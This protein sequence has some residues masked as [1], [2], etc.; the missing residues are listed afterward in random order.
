M[1][2]GR[3]EAAQ[4]A[5]EAAA[6]AE[7]PDGARLEELAAR[8]TRARELYAQLDSAVMDAEGARYAIAAAART[9]QDAHDRLHEVLAEAGQC[10]T[11]GAVVS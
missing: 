4:A 11:C 9:E 3:L 6:P 8:L 5:L 2:T 7:V 10:P 1:L